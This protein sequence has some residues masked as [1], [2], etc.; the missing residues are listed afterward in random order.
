M[1]ENEFKI[2]VNHNSKHLPL[3]LRV[4]ANFLGVELNVTL[5]Q[6]EGFLRNTPLNSKVYMK[7]AT[8]PVIRQVK[9]EKLVSNELM[10]KFYDFKLDYN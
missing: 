4:I 7:N 9:T 6:V 5:R 10:I 1:D 3:K 8:S 2:I